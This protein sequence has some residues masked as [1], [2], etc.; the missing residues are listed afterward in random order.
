MDKHSHDSDEQSKDHEVQ[1]QLVKELPPAHLHNEL[2][3]FIEAFRYLLIF[4]RDVVYYVS[5]VA[6]ALIRLSHVLVGLLAD[7]LNVPQLILLVI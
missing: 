7:L 4:V 1:T 6:Q 3:P 2:V 5:L